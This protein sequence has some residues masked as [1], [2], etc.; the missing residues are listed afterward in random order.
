MNEADL[1]ALVI[2]LRSTTPLVRL[3]HDE[4]K[5]VVTAIAALLAAPKAAA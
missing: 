1:D 5:S 4:A 2:K 3:G